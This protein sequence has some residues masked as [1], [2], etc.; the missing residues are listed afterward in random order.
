ME[1]VNLDNIEY[2]TDS[3][4]NVY[5]VDLVNKTCKKVCSAPKTMGID[6]IGD[7]DIPTLG[8]DAY[9]NYLRDKFM[10]EDCTLKNGRL[11]FRGY[12]ISL[13]AEDGFVIEDTQNHYEIVET[14]FE[15]IPTPE[16]LGEWFAAPKRKELSDEEK[17]KEYA[18]A[19]EEGKRRERSKKEEREQKKASDSEEVDFEELRGKVL[20]EIKALKEKKSDFDVDGF[21]DFIPFKRWRRKTNALLKQLHN[22]E[23]RRPKFLNELERITSEET[24]ELEEKRHRSSFVGTELPEHKSVG[25]LKGDKLEVDGKWID[26]V[27]FLVEYLLHYEPRCMSQ[28]MKWAEGSITDDELLSNPMDVDWKVEYRSKAFKNSE[29][30]AQIISMVYDIVGIVAPQDL[31][32]ETSLK[33]GDVILLM[34]D[35]E[36]KRRTISSVEQ[37]VSI[38]RGVGLFKWDRYVLAPKK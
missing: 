16:E 27:P 29:H 37:G 24:F 1:K 26:A 14:S 34:V 28:L 11:N 20:A 17:A 9:R 7:F 12:R 2:G 5:V 32:F 31:L 19:V 30:N 38:G 6:N 3:K 15:G 36:L 35:G 23:I 25:F 33:A 8:L 21:K 18:D 22:K 4:G 10:D 13:T